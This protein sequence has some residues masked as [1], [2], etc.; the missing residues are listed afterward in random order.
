VCRKCDLLGDLLQENMS[1]CPKVPNPCDWYR[2]LEVIILSRKHCPLFSNGVVRPL[3]SFFENRGFGVC[4]VIS[5]VL[6]HQ[7]LIYRQAISRRRSLLAMHCG[8][9]AR[10]YDQKADTYYA[11]Y[12]SKATNAVPRFT[13]I[14]RSK[15]DHEQLMKARRMATR[16]RAEAACLPCKAKKVRCGNSRPCSR[17][18]LIPGEMCVDKRPI[19]IVNWHIDGPT[20]DSR[21]TTVAPAFHKPNFSKY[22][23]YNSPIDHN[24]LLVAVDAWEISNRCVLA[25]RHISMTWAGYDNGVSNEWVWEAAAGPGKDD[26]FRNDWNWGNEAAK[27]E[28]STFG[29]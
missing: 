25:N 2:I 10:H 5:S 21:V 12:H 8:M 1:R 13:E 22:L 19:Q 29:Q 18:S 17:C 6:H 24:S 20:S 23:L 9:H 27:G 16:R 11:P 26:P 3:L 28:F 14:S 7:N 4:L 15:S